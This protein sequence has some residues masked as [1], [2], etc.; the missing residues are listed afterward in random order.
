MNTSNI[1]AMLF[2]VIQDGP[3]L[4]SIPGQV[5]KGYIGCMWYMH[6]IGDI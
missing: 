3:A 4:G 1:R 6:E 2:I 5:F